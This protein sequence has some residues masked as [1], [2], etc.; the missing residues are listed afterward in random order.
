MHYL[1]LCVCF[2][3]PAQIYVT[4]EKDVDKAMETNYQA[5]VNSSIKPDGIENPEDSKKPEDDEKQYQAKF[6]WLLPDLVE[7]SLISMKTESNRFNES[8]ACIYNY[9]I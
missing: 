1:Y 3:E 8:I 2:F 6:R 9:F 7:R 5:S 4:N